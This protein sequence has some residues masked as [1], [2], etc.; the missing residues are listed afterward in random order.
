MIEFQ[1]FAHLG[2]AT[3]IQHHN[4]V[5]QGHRF[6]LIVGD[7]NHGAAQTLVQAGDFNTHLHAQRGVEVRQRLIEQEHARL[8]HQRTANRHTLTLTTGERLRLTL[9]QVCQ[10]ENFGNL[11]HALVNGLF[12]GAGQLQAERH[13]LGNGE[14]GIKCIGLEYHPDAALRRRDIVHTGIANHQ[15]TAG[16]GFQTGNHA[17]QRGF[18]T[19]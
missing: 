7:V 2:H 14:M 11:G 9:Q 17:Q 13:V 5:G 15:I 12:F 8:C 1:R 10:L 6:D 18:T 4:L 19:A 16:D 3:G